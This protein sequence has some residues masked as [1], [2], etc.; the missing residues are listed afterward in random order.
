[1]ALPHPVITLL[2]VWADGLARS[3]V[4]AQRLR[5]LPNVAAQDRAMGLALLACGDE[6]VLPGPARAL[7]L[8]F[9]AQPDWLGHDAQRRALLL[10]RPILAQQLAIQLGKAASLLHAEPPLALL[11]YDQALELM[12]ELG[13][14]WF[15]RGLLRR[16]LGQVTA[17]AE[18]LITACRLQPDWVPAWQEAAHSLLLSGDIEGALRLAD[19]GLGHLPEAAGLWLVKGNLLQ[20]LGL[21]AQAMAAYQ[22]SLALDPQQAGVWS[23]LGLVC[24]HLLQPEQALDCYERALAL[25]TGLAEVW[26]NLATLQLDRGD[27]A[28]AEACLNRCLQLLPGYYPAWVN[29]GLLA[30]GLGQTQLALQLFAQARQ[31]EPQRPEAWLEEAGLLFEQQRDFEAFHLLEQGSARVTRPGAL[32]MMQGRNLALRHQFSAGEALMRQAIAHE[33]ER[34]FWRFLLEVGAPEAR[35]YRSAAE[36]QAYI[37]ALAARLPAWAAQPFAPQVYL[38]ESGSLL[39]DSLWSLAYLSSEPQTELKRLYAACFAPAAPPAP[40]PRSSDSK[41][42][43]R[44]G[45]LVTPGHEG[46]FLKLGLHLLAALPPEQCEVLLLGDPERLGERLPVVTLPPKVAAAAAKIQALELDL[47]YYWEVGSDMLN[48]FLPGFAPA[49]VQFT[50]WGTPATTGHPAMNYYL[51]SARL[52]A[53]DA[54]S[55]Y[56]ET[57]LLMDELP[58]FFPDPQPAAGTSDRQTLGLPATGTLYL[59]LNNPLKFTPEFLVLLADILAQD[60]DGQLILLASRRDWINQALQPAMAGLEPFAS[61]IY[62]QD[63]PVPRERFLNLMQIADIGLDTLVYSGGQVSHEALALG[64][65][66]ITLPGRAAHSR[67][68]LSRWHQL[69]LDD[70]I[71][72][73][74]AGYVKRTL[75]LARNSARRADLRERLLARRERL[76]NRHEAVEQFT[77]LLWQMAREAGLRTT[78]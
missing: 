23:N 12:P 29:R 69:G 41:R 54:A 65:P 43:L 20:A 59:C 18:D 19:Q 15:F 63:A 30:G 58:T 53:P 39:V 72:S 8:A 50:S 55:H 35:F 71:A 48:F 24:Q 67:L 51:S 22:Q 37:D 61:R 45:V 47:L 56:S 13:A 52:E 60:P 2:R 42:P 73:D 38:A 28:Q 57:L 11:L 17:A 5:E 26:N 33:P 31:L 10:A 76:L 77:A 27:Q 36:R 14:G 6:T 49:P 40:A 21:P 74:A 16:S 70:G 64:L 46:I 9:R 34:L 4:L 66:V 1:M 68:T 25:D 62:W 3:E 32:K 78:I 75:E 7:A 44:L